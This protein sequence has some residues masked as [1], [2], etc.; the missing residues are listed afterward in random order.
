MW[1]IKFLFHFT[2]NIN[3]QVLFQFSKYLLFLQCWRIIY[4]SNIN[5]PYFP[6]IYHS[7]AWLTKILFHFTFNVYLQVLCHFSEYLFLLQSI[8]SIYHSKINL[9]IFFQFTIAMCG[10]QKLLFYFTLNVNLQDL[11]HFS[12]FFIF[13][14]IQSWRQIYHSNISSLIFT[15]IYS[16]YLWFTKFLFHFKFNIILKILWHFSNILFFLYNHED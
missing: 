5:L 4:H 1:F 16:S 6:L 8:R 12:K 13:I 14:F 10:L 9:S 7:Y 15:L 3:L 11:C 2:F